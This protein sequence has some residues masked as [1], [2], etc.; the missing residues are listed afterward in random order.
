MT[1]L[2][3]SYTA[4]MPQKQPP[5]STIVCN[6]P[7]AGGGASSV[8]A[9]TDD[10]RLGLRQSGRDTEK[11]EKCNEEH[12]ANH[13]TT[14]EAATDATAATDASTCRHAACHLCFLH[15]SSAPPDAASTSGIFRPIRASRANHNYRHRTA[16]RG[17]DIV[18][19]A[20][21]RGGPP[22][23]VAINP[24]TISTIPDNKKPLRLPKNPGGRVEI[25]ADD[26]AKPEIGRCPHQASDHRDSD[27]FGQAI[28]AHPRQQARH[29]TEIGD[30]GARDEHRH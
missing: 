10:G 23:T 11:C 26:I 15:V 29:R 18:Y 21:T 22:D 1:P 8:G 27:E 24:T 16:L 25:G 20:R 28:T 17:H 5:A 30:K 3:C 4:C 19:R 12:R 13:W 14:R 9:G 6:P 2:V 7:P